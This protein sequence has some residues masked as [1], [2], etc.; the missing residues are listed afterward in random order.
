MP[1]VTLLDVL[2]LLVDTSTWLD[3]SKC[4][5]GQRWIVAIRVLINQEQLELVVPPVEQSLA[6]YTALGYAEFGR[7]PEAEFGSLMMI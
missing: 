3:L 1:A 5:D 4:R 2:H 7:V 6:S